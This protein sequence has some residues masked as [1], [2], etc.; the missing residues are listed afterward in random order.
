[1]SDQTNNAPVRPANPVTK[2]LAIGRLTAKVTEPAVFLALMPQEVPAT[3]NLYLDGKIEQ[4]WVKSDS[5]GVVFLLNLTDVN[6]AYEVLEALPLG[7]AGLMEFDLIPLG[8]LTPLRFL[9]GNAAV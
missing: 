7:V 3:V 5:S 8:P 4:W 2:I 1:M 9:L 6:E